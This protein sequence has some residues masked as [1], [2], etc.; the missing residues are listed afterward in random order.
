MEAEFAVRL[1]QRSESEH[2]LRYTTMLCDGDSKAFDAVTESKC[3]G[4]DKEIVKEDCIN[5][6]SKRMGTALKN[7]VSTAKA[8]KESISG[9]GKLTKEKISK[10]QNYYGR[11][12]KDNSEDITHMKKRIYAILFHMTSSDDY[13]K[14]VH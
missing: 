3:Y 9:K 6:V 10:M 8:Q 2:Q 1:W 11:A 14:H 4:P 7:L 12:I 5:H 13:P